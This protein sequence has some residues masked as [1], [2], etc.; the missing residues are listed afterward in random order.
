MLQYEGLSSFTL[1]F[2]AWHQYNNDVVFINPES[3][4]P[5]GLGFRDF[6]LEVPEQ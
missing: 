3:L 4:N 1:D 5:W 6:Y 2:Y